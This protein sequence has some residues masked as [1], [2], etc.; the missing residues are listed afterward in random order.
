MKNILRTFCLLAVLLFC[1]CQKEKD[2]TFL[3]T[4]EQIGKLKK[5]SLT[6][7][8][9]LIYEE[10]SIVRDTVRGNFGSNASKIQIFEKGGKKLLTLTPNR[11]SIPS[12]ENILINDP[13]F[14]TDNGINTK[15][16]FKDIKEKYAIK[17]II[18]SLNNV[19]ILLKDSDIYFTIDKK[20]LPE[21]LRYKTNTNIEEVQIP[22]V[23]KIK[24]MMISWDS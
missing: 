12:I 22:D 19:L 16:T 10:D 3:I 1:Q 5:N 9:E 17:K 18:T 21:N 20:E 15:S 11:D 2:T 14:T 13:R 7:D 6:R 8:I 24:Y 4:S 23:A